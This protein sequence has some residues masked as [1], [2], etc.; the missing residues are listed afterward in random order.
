M[1]IPL[2]LQLAGLLEAMIRQRALRPGDK[3]PS[4]RRFSAEQRV[5]VPTA[6]N[7]YA[8]LEAR[9]LIEARPKSGFYVTASRADSI[10]T[11]LPSKPAL[12]VSDLAHSDPLEVLASTLYDPSVVQFGSAVAQPDLLPGVRLSRILSSVA[13]RLGPAAGNYEPPG[14]PLPLR[15]EI[16]KRCL[17]AGFAVGSPEQI[18]IT[19][20]ATEAIALALA[21]TCSP[22]D[23][24]IVE[25]PT[26][27]G[28]LRQLR[29]FGLKALP[30][31]MH[32]TEG[33][34]L[35][36]LA[37]ALARNKV[38]AMLLVPNFHNPTG[39]VMPDG[40]KRELVRLAASQ[41]I[42]I[43]EDDIFG[44]T[45]HRGPRPHA[46]KAFD[47]DAT[48]LH[49]GC[50]SKVIAPGYRVGYI[51]AGG[52]HARVCALKRA[53]NGGNALLPS[54]AI[55]EFLR[56]GGYDRYLRSFREACRQQVATLRDAIGESFPPGIRLSR[57]E[58]SF[59]LWCEMPRQVDSLLLFKQ[60]LAAGITI[61]PGPM[62]STAGEFRNFFRLNCG[63]RWS[64]QI[65]RAVA[66][67]GRLVRAQADK[68]A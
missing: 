25:S 67:L 14:G 6:L 30:I 10:P 44:D 50:F 53:Q 5:S 26:F 42:P 65:E 16:A 29:E 41:G 59:V 47:Q 54:L 32:P 35:D 40:N 62:F 49:C 55:A 27:F 13:R 34:D 20:G 21:A 22:G 57:P 56:S 11:I 46:L 15:R 58:G 39:S 17:T 36:V 31:P 61:A 24:V 9:G 3:I 52:F 8:K 68:A 1:G 48:V 38:S 51:I 43:I 63:F 37:R 7:A 64:G 18:L 23:T 33:L 45:P 66:T 4:V 60:A 28:L 2:Y 19:L 12:K